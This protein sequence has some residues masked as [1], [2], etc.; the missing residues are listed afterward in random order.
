[1]VA[2]RSLDLALAGKAL[3]AVLQ[4]GELGGR[5]AVAFRAAPNLALV[6]KGDRPA[7]LRDGAEDDLA[8]VGAAAL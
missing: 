8:L 3:L 1:M 5:L 7:F 4:C 6:V 2:L